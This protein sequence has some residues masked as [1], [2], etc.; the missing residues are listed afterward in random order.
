MDDQSKLPRPTFPKA[1]WI[2]VFAPRKAQKSSLGSTCN[3]FLAAL[4][5]LGAHSDTQVRG[6]TGA[7]G[8]DL[9]LLTPALRIALTLRA[10]MHLKLSFLMSVMEQ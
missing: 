8:S 2:H 7:V 4:L 10:V 1:H 5:A 3:A 9:E 6:C